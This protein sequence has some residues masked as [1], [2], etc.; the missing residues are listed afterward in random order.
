MESDSSD[1]D[2]QKRPSIPRK[3]SEGSSQND[4]IEL[5]SSD[6]EG[7][8]K[9]MQRAARTAIRKPVAAAE[10]TT[11]VPLKRPPA[12]VVSS[13]AKAV[14]IDSSDDEVD[15]ELHIEKLRRQGKG[16]ALLE[17]L[18]KKEPKIEMVDRRHGAGDERK[19][20]T[21]P[22]PI[23]QSQGRDVIKAKLEVVDERK[24]PADP[25]RG[26]AQ[27]TDSQSVAATQIQKQ[28]PAKDQR[29]QAPLLTKESK[30]SN[31]SENSG[32]TLLT[33][34]AAK[35]AATPLQP[36]SID[37]SG[38]TA[39]KAVPKRAASHDVLCL[40]DSSDN[41]DG[42]NDDDDR[43]KRSTSSF[44]RVALNGKV[45]S[46]DDS[47]D[48]GDSQTIRPPTKSGTSQEFAIYLSSGDDDS[49][50]DDGR[51]CM[52]AGKTHFA[53]RFNQLSCLASPSS[54]ASQI[55]N[56]GN[57]SNY[58]VGLPNQ[59][60]AK[61]LVKST[62]FAV[63]EKFR[64]GHRK[65]ELDENK[66]TV[67]P[68]DRNGHYS[69]LGFSIKQNGTTKRTS[70]QP[71]DSS[72]E[73][74]CSSKDQAVFLLKHSNVSRKISSSEKGEGMVQTISSGSDDGSSKVSDGAR[75]T[76]AN[77]NDG[78]QSHSWSSGSEY[79][80]TTKGAATFQM[81]KPDRGVGTEPSNDA[82]PEKAIRSAGA[83]NNR[84][85]SYPGNVSTG[86]VRKCLQAGNKADVRRPKKTS[87]KSTGRAL[88]QRS[89]SKDI[90][91]CDGSTQLNDA[92]LRVKKTP[93]KSIGPIGGR[94]PLAGVEEE[95]DYEYSLGSEEEVDIERHTTTFT[96]IS[97]LSKRRR[98]Q[99]S[100]KTKGGTALEECLQSY[101]PRVRKETKRKERE[102]APTPPLEAE[103]ES[104]DTFVMI[105]VPHLGGITYRNGLP[106]QRI[107]VYA[108]ND[109]KFISGRK[110]AQFNLSLT[111]SAD[112]ILYDFEVN[113]KQSRVSKNAGLGAFLMY[114]GA[115][116][117][118]KQRKKVN[119]KKLDDRD[120][121]N[122][123]TLEYLAARR[124]DG[125]TVSIQ[126]SGK[127]LHGHNNAIFRTPTEVPLR[128]TV[129]KTS[130]RQKMTVRLHGK[131]LHHDIDED[132]SFDLSCCPKR[133]G[134][135]CLN[136]ESDYT[137]DNTIPFSAKLANSFSIELGRYGPVRKTGKDQ[138]VLIFSLSFF[139]RALTTPR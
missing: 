2:K 31:Q 64:R 116:V 137:R 63:T 131:N 56:W 41:D 7:L 104:A 58:K 67:A 132:G 54:E 139:V 4:P 115:R 96:A 15:M 120:I 130:G 117:L 36:A 42:D 72:D 111:L 77:L 119:L 34:Y 103:E 106:F 57:S 55:K 45:V 27:K 40:D 89:E 81:K 35:K 5:E 49:E 75:R 65:T 91:T 26:R 53:S 66:D 134:R 39:K 127:H 90:R 1:D 85:G 29:K 101:D 88:N 44:K 48:D 100:R 95:S 80:D 9:L 32:M 51:E 102:E 10:S 38:V 68:L 22:R 126:I 128:A 14:D 52:R 121:F 37:H 33:K 109:G 16:V 30:Q 73:A 118:D 25:N 61:P 94:K 19:K 3:L 114:R 11:V 98:Q 124:Q 17:T 110:F 74:S 136:V 70:R 82:P 135:L 23:N 13:P 92:V 43:P 62:V 8:V 12:A 86:P 47:S 99:S 79:E 76:P 125:S 129:Y 113:I 122:P 46:I 123:T 59:A 107:T 18:V 105:E 87:R 21:N 60:E 108:N 71:I 112:S 133:F 84:E 78:N 50:S 83:A 24:R 20:P 6:E 69:R 138:Q 93:R 97:T 28:I